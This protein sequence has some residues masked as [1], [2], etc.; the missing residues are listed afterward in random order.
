MFTQAAS[1]WL[2][3]EALKKSELTQILPTEISQS[4]LLR[5]IP[6]RFSWE[7]ITDDSKLNVQKMSDIDVHVEQVVGRHSSPSTLEVTEHIF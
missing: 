1:F 2:L 7:E 5:V 3:P 4:Y 6:I